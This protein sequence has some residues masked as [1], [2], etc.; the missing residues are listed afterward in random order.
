MLNREI[1]IATKMERPFSRH[2]SSSRSL[3][4]GGLGFEHIGFPTCFLGSVT[5]NVFILFLFFT[6]F[7]FLSFSLFF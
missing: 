4:K 2:T 5:P 6:F 7:N 1:R 3:R